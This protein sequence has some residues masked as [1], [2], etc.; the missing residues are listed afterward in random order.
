MNLVVS[1]LFLYD[2]KWLEVLSPE[3]IKSCKVIERQHPTIREKQKGQRMLE[4]GIKVWLNFN[5]K[6]KRSKTKVITVGNLED[7]VRE[8]ARSQDLDDQKVRLAI[9]LITMIKRSAERYNSPW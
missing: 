8:Q 3:Q 6:F 1:V 9:S 5:S 7:M 2:D 4:A